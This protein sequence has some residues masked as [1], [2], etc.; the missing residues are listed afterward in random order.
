MKTR[1]SKRG[2]P[3]A[4]KPR[5]AAKER[6]VSSASITRSFA[7]QVAGFIKRYRPALEA[8]AKR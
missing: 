3:A 4:A 8:L 2:K 6:P 1:K 5:P 7:S